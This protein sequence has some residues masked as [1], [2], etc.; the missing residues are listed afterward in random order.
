MRIKKR[1]QADQDNQVIKEAY[2]SVME[3]V[4]ILPLLR[5][6]GK[7]GAMYCPCSSFSKAFHMV[8]FTVTVGTFVQYTLSK[9]LLQQHIL[10]FSFKT[11]F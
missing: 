10:L 4:F 2:F 9:A 5:H 11:V 3:D 6:H 7:K 8:Y 1:S